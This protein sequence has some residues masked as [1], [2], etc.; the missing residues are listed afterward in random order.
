MPLDRVV[1]ITDETTN[2][3]FLNETVQNVWQ[4]IENDSPNRILPDPQLRL[5]RLEQQSRQEVQQLLKLLCTA[6]TNEQYKTATI[7][8]S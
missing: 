6:V 3:E 5:L 7:P 1:L 4:E 2:V 8:V